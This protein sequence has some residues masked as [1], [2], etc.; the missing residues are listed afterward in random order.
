MVAELRALELIYEKSA[1]PE[2]AFMFKHALTHDVAYS[3][4][5]LERRKALH[6]IVA[7][8]IEELYADR[9]QEHHEALAHHYYE[10]QEWEKAL[11]Y[12]VKAAQKATAAYANQDALDYY[13]RALQAC[14]RLGDVPME[15]VMGIYGG[16]AEVSLTINDWTAVVANY[17]RLRELAS[18]AGNH[19]VEGLALGGVAWGHVWTHEFD[20]A[21]AAAQEA[22]ALADKL[23]DDAIRAGGV[24]VLGWL[25]GT[26]GNLRAC[27]ETMSQAIR[28]SQETGQPAYELL[29]RGFQIMTHSWRALYEQAHRIAAEAVAAS[30]L[31][32]VTIPLLFN[33]WNQGLAFAGHGRY[34]DAI[35]ALLDA[36]ALCERMGDKAFQSRAWNTLGWA[37]GELCNWEKGIEYNRRGLELAHV[38][39]D[40]EITINAQINLADYAF[41]TGEREQARRE[42]EE[43][44]ASLPE[45]HE[46]MKWRYSQ[47][48]MHSLGEVLLATG[49]AERALSLAD[50]CLALAEPTETRKNIVKG[51]RL[52]GQVFLAQGKLV[53]V[54]KELAAALKI[55]EDIGNPPQ[56]W[57]THAALG[58][59]RQAQGKPDDA[60]Q[61]YR[62]ALSVIDGVAAG[63]EDESLRETFLGSDHVQ[64][65]RR[66]AGG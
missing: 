62:D 2:L 51:R 8:A 52:R 57:K 59:L 47:H 20:L 64:G 5:L 6:R 7:A 50:E 55:A 13:D 35:A 37:H 9:L 30:E 19:G 45:L 28:L 26:R 16:K 48:I 34:D 1:H 46:W 11:D 65:I 56:L 17:S 41:A 49:E 54:E 24:F 32:H 18:A 63:L 23:N 12:L 21:E 43:L 60:R 14:D 25:D 53:E 4:L 10:G 66:A 22:L 27:E 15:T 3:T 40:P 42:L 39:G 58:D 38:V 31:H 33:K 61:A 36:L 44:Y 29:G